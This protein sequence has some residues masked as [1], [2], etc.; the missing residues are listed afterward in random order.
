[1][2]AQYKYLTMRR[3]WLLH[4]MKNPPK[5]QKPIKTLKSETEFETAEEEEE[6]EKEEK[7][8]WGT[9]S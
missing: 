1:M 7:R 3:I 5:T 4:F 2:A 9:V 6:E 8:N